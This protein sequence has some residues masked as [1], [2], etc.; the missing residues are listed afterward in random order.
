M[1]IITRLK[2]TA[3]VLLA[4]AITACSAGNASP[5]ITP[6]HLPTTTKVRTIDWDKVHEVRDLTHFLVGESTCAPTDESGS[7]ELQQELSALLDELQN[8]GENTYDRPTPSQVVSIDVQYSEPERNN[9]FLNNLGS[10]YRISPNYIVTAAHLF[11]RDYLYPQLE[12]AVASTKDKQLEILYAQINPKDDIALLRVVSPSDA[13]TFGMR[14]DVS[15]DVKVPGTMTKI[16]YFEGENY[17]EITEIIPKGEVWPVKYVD[18]SV[19]SRGVPEEVNIKYISWDWTYG[20]HLN[21]SPPERI[22]IVGDLEP[23]SS[24]SPLLNDAHELL[25]VLTKGFFTLNPDGIVTINSDGSLN[26]TPTDKFEATGIHKL[27]P[28]LQEELDTV[29]ACV[30]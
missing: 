19:A 28:L 15:F 29:E 17:K 1:G 24:G 12:K 5:S 18:R 20:R 26:H 16:T 21:G 27:G 30:Q 25:G 13:S 22:G 6:T 9:D 7:Y 8:P 3:L 11:E 23:G 14:F 2:S 4:L 10:G